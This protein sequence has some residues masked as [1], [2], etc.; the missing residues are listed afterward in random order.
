MY[1][2]MYVNMYTLYPTQIKFSHGLKDSL[3][4][5]KSIYIHIYKHMYIYTHTYVYTH[6]HIYLD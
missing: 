4:V 5:Q 6:I 2:L 1:I 3:I